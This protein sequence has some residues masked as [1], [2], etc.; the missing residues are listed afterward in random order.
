[1]LEGYEWLGHLGLDLAEKNRILSAHRVAVASLETLLGQ[2]RDAKQAGRSLNSLP[3]D[4]L[5]AAPIIARGQLSPSIAL[6]QIDTPDKLESGLTSELAAQSQTVKL[7]ED[8]IAGKQK[9][10]TSLT[11]EFDQLVEDRIHTR[12]NYQTIW[13]KV[14]EI[15]TQAAT[16]SIE[17]R[18]IQAAELPTSPVPI[19]WPLIGILALAGGGVIGLAGCYVA[20]FLE[21]RGKGR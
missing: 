16:D 20:E 5:D 14:D 13:R 11:T 19:Q 10:M 4:S 1:M 3:W 15:R 2:F 21:H 6:S 18:V 8:E 17:L 7:L 9:E 12:E